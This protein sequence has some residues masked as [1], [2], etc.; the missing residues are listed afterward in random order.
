MRVLDGLPAVPQLLFALLIVTFL[1][2]DALRSARAGASDVIEALRPIAAPAPTGPPTAAL[3]IFKR[4][5]EEPQVSA[6]YTSHDLGFVSRIAEHVSVRNTGVIVESGARE[7][8]FAEPRDSDTKALITA[9]PNPR[10]AWCGGAQLGGAGALAGEQCHREIR[11][12]I[13]F[14]F[15]VERSMVICDESTAALTRVTRHMSKREEAV[16]ALRSVCDLVARHTDMIFSDA[17]SGNS[18]MP[19]FDV[20]NDARIVTA[21]NAA[22]EALQ[23]EAQP[24]GAIMPLGFYVTDAGHL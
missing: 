24:T 23:G 6:L 12:A 5:R 10:A 13:A 11:P 7:A 19:A 8:V 15:A 21:Q 22:Y 18:Q 4:L 9:V 14:A 20:P 17:P 3:D 16:D 2:G 1:G